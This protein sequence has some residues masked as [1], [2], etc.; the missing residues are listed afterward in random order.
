MKRQIMKSESPQ[1]FI[2]Y[3]NP[4]QKRVTPFFEFLDR[5]GFKVWFDIKSLR[6]GQNWDFEI[7][8]ALDKSNIIIV[9]LSKNS[10]DRRS[11]VQREIKIAISKLEEKLVDD[12]YIIPVLLDEDILIPSQLK[13]IQAISAKASNCMISLRDAVQ[14]QLEKLG[15]ETERVQH[16]EEISWHFKILEE[17]WEGLPGYETTTQFITFQSTKYPAVADIGDYIRGDL[18]NGIFAARTSKFEQ[19]PKFYNYG[20]DSYWRTNTYDAHCSEPVIVNKILTIKYTIHTYG[21]GAAHGNTGFMTYSFIINPLFRIER[22]DSI[23]TF[24]ENAFIKIQ[25]HVR[26]SLKNH[27][28]EDT[29]SGETYQLDAAFIDEG[30]QVWDDFACFIPKEDGIEFLFSP[31]QVAAYAFGPQSAFVAYQDLVAVMRHEYICALGI[32]HI[33]PCGQH[34]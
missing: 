32:E 7:K 29:E 17:N 18:L 28:I 13:G 6:P 16:A 25:A 9:F 22:L 27:L 11:Y 1:V 10:I 14:Y 4:D 2:S 5:E 21:A 30:T 34:S 23:F 33:L 26:E 3:A 20:Q 12:I 24:P 19:D 15:L 8:R 31:Y